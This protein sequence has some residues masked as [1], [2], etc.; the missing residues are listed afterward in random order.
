MDFF[1]TDLDKTLLR[2]D[3]SISPFTKHVWNNFTKP[4]SIA[5]ARSFTGVK[6]LLSGLDLKYP[7]ILLDGALITDANGEVMRVNALD[8]STA[9]EIVEII[10]KEF[11]E[12]PLVVAMDE[13]MQERFIYPHKPNIHQQELLQ[14]YH[15][16]RRIFSSKKME[17]ERNN[18]KIVYLGKKELLEGIEKRV[19]EIFDVESKLSEDPYQN[20]HFLTLLH[21]LGDKAHALRELKHFI[22]TDT[23]NIT[24]F[25]DSHNDIGMF[26]LAKKAIAVKNALPAVQEEADLVLPYTNDE[27]GVA[28]YLATL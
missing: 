14:K 2:S 1:I 28:K 20:C 5:T 8:K 10:A 26:R 12:F 16:D 27:D 6:K 17:V 3:L 15:N 23:E 4:L 22:E 24:V 13:K 9:Q 25:G 19:C 11:G 18:L 21:P 7:M